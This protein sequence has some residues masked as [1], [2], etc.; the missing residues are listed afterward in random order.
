[1]VERHLPKLLVGED[2]F[3]VERL[4]DIMWRGTLYYGRKGLAVH[5]ISAVDNALWDLIGKSLGT[6]VYQ[7]LGGSDRQRVP[8]YCTGNNIQQAVEFGFRKLKLA[9]PYGPAD[10][11]EGLD[12]NEQLVERA[13]AAC[14]SPRRDHARLLDGADRVLR[15]ENGRAAGAVWCVLDG[16]VPDAR[17]LCGHGT[18]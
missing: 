3:Q 18:A 9:V 1:M 7:L 16:G 8:A 17:R 2:P 6:P 15:R 13:A 4:W 10:G 14:R 11:E 12:K 5:A